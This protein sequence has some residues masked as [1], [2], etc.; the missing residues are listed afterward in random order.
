MEAFPVGL[1]LRELEILSH[2]L[3]VD[4]DDI[5]NQLGYPR[6]I[7]LCFEVVKRIRS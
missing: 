1:R 5:T 7:I 3:Y 2:L 6:H 4:W